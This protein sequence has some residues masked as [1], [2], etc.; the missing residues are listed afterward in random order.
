M[1]GKGKSANTLPP[2]ILLK[3]YAHIMSFPIETSHYTGTVIKYIDERLDIKC[4]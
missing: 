4:L 1:R 3:M 2:E